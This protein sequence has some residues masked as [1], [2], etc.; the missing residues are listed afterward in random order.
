MNTGSTLVYEHRGE[1]YCI[2]GLGCEAQDS[3]LGFE[4]YCLGFENYCLGIRVQFVQFVLS[5]Y[6]QLEGFGVVHASSWVERDSAC[7]AQRLSSFLQLTPH[8]CL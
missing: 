7:L 4:N 5:F 8:A 2:L 3:G 6:F 1:E